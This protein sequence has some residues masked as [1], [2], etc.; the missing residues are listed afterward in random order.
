MNWSFEEAQR[1]VWGLAKS[2][3]VNPDRFAQLLKACGETT[4]FPCM[5]FAGS[6]GKGSVCA[7]CDAALRHAGKKVGRYT[8]PHLNNIT[9]RI[10]IDGNPIC[11]QDFAA[12][13]QRVAH[14]AQTCALKY[15]P[16]SPFEVLTATALLYF[17][18][19]RVDVAVIE[20][21]L[22][23]RLD[24][25]RHV[26]A[27]VTGITRIAKEHTALL[28]NTLAQIA[29]EKAGILKQGIPAVI[30]PQQGEALKVLLRQAQAVG[31]PAYPI[32][33]QDIVR[34][35][36]TLLARRMDVRLPSGWLRNLEIGL[37]GGYQ[38]ENAA[39]AAAALECAGVRE[40][41]IR[42]GL[43]EV[44]WP[45]RMQRLPLYGRQ[46]LLDGAHNTSGAAVL[47]QSL[48]GYYPDT[49]ITLVLGIG[50]VK[51]AAGMLDCL[52]PHA[53]R[54]I[55]T[56]SG[57]SSA[58]SP[59][60]LHDLARQHNSTQVPVY[61]TP[62]PQQALERAIDVAPMAG[63]ILVCGS[64]YLVGEMLQLLSREP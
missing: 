19:Q 5:H 16:A 48:A 34:K 28:G 10:A 39:L 29:M 26:T 17:A 50:A 46:F 38:F 56:S 42:F 31:A 14:A 47:A 52:L 60:T 59:E 64:L 11:A 32:A 36:D 27:Q 55:A 40:A 13:I 58:L 33:Q 41:S 57:E 8:S 63:L 49:D 44:A 45:G 25:T 51:D 2:Q 3:N 22:G 37:L 61:S 62:G 7:F 20:T 24:P 18:Q 23:G 21:G 9:E 43:K 35:E 15:G 30:A 12:T 1:Y 4:S 54:M 53:T 6:N